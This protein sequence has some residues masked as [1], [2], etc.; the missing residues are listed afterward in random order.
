MTE[1]TVLSKFISWIEHLPSTSDIGG[2]NPSQDAS[3]WEVG[4]YLPMPSG[5]QWGM[6]PRRKILNKK[7]GK[8]YV[9]KL[10]NKCSCVLKNDIYLLSV[11]RHA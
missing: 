6:L 2:S 5:L 4:S 7:I 9:K 3:C 10:V 1:E 11:L 8:T